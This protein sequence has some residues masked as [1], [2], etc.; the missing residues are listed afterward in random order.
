MSERGERGGRTRRHGRAD[1]GLTRAQAAAGTL[2]VVVLGVTL[3]LVLG[4]IFGRAEG[5]R[6]DGRRIATAFDHDDA[7]EEAGIDVASGSFAVAD[8]VLTATQVPGEGAAVALADRH[9][10]EGRLTVTAAAPEPGWA[11]VVRWEGPDDHWSVTVPSAG[12][13]PELVR[14]AGGEAEVVAVA[15]A[16]LAPGAVVDVRYDDRRVDVRVDGALVA[17]GRGDAVSGRR[18]GLAATAPGAA[19]DDLEIGPRPRPVVRS[20]G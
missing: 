3:V 2:G 18:V 19:W 5:S 14:V 17:H 13:P 6:D 1:P 16:P 20:E 10:D 11:V 12:G 4:V 9:A 7:L 15:T 8:G